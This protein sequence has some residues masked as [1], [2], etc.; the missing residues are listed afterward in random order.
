MKLKVILIML[1]FTVLTLNAY[2]KEKNIVKV[3][4]KT[5]MGDIEL[6]LDRGIAPLTVDNF[7]GLAEGTKDFKDPKTNEM[8]K[9]N[10]YDGLIFHRVIK[11]FMIQGG[12]PL[13]T[14]TGGPGYSFEDECF[15]QGDKIVGLIDDDE[16]AYVVYTQL[17]I[18]YL[19]TRPES[20]DAELMEIVQNCQQAQSFDPMK[21]KDVSFYENATKMGPVYAIGDLKA[22]VDYGTIC[23]ANA[24]PNTNGSQ[25]FI[26]TKQGGAEWLNGK[27][28]VFGKVTK[29]MDVVHK[30]EDVEKGAG[31]K[32]ANDVKILSVRVV[33]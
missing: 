8:T 14:G 17:V 25:F 24:G 18:P 20:P 33:K 19:Q 3:L 32:P 9:R 15:E 7:I 12:C 1:L 4:M 10:Y 13:G 2:A 16:K 29:G 11:D 23:M 30:I 21:G 22:T 6:A 5:S 27:H 26:V 31:D 28:T